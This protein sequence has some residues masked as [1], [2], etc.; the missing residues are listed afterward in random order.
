MSRT[1]R[2]ARSHSGRA[3]AALWAV[4]ASLGAAL[5]VGLM[6]VPVL[7]LFLRTTPQA[8]L[9]H[10]RS[11]Q[12]LAALRLSLVTAGSSTLLVVL[13]GSP[14][15]YLLAFRRF[16]GRGLVRTLVELPMVLPPTVAG[17]ALLL[18]LG[19]AGLLGGGLSALG[20]QLP[21]TTAAVVVAQVFMSAPFFVTG[22][23]AGFASVDRSHLEVAATLGAR[24]PFTFFHVVL[25]LRAPAL[26]AGAT[27]AAARALAEFGATITFA[28]NLPGRTQTMPLAVYMAM[29]SDLEGAVVLAVLLVLMSVALLAVLR[30]LRPGWSGS[31]DA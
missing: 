2:T 25:P 21:F 19:R 3:V 18:A 6:A 9:A 24:A 1:T 15:A 28:G 13:L 7:A 26:F 5:I 30:S 29:E 11:P 31:A 20:I 17:L 23:A 14:V 22:A 12:V 8:V 4:A 16:R 10:L 27:M